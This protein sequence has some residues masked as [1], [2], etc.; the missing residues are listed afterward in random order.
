[1]KRQPRFTVLSATTDTCTQTNLSSLFAPL[2]QEGSEALDKTMNIVLP[3]DDDISNAL[4]YLFKVAVVA[5]GHY[6]DRGTE[7]P[8]WVSGWVPVWVP[9]FPLMYV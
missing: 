1:M 7:E 6:S 3:T 4:A 2:C 9:H 5:K 8:G